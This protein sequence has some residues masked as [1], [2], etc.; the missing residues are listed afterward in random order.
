MRARTTIGFDPWF[1]P[2]MPHGS[3]K[4]LVGDFRFTTFPPSPDLVLFTE[5]WR[6][7][8]AARTVFKFWRLAFLLTLDEPPPISFQYEFHS[9]NLCPQQ[10]SVRCTL[11]IPEITYIGRPRLVSAST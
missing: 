4:T 7:H 10:L 2:I 3:R 8:T 6:H 11:G 5:Q 9:L 1:R